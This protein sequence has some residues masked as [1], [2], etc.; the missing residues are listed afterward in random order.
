[1][2]QKLLGL[3]SNP[4]AV[5]HS[6]KTAQQ[7]ASEEE[8]RETVTVLQAAAA[9]MSQEPTYNRISLEGQLILGQQELARALS[10]HA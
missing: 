8:H 9:K 5:A 4:V 2:V 3:G 10:H 7:L 1:V 6:G